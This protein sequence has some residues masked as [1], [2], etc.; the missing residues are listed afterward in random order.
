MK[1]INSPP[2]SP[3][4][5]CAQSCQSVLHRDNVRALLFCSV[6]DCHIYFMLSYVDCYVHVAESSGGTARRNATQRRKRPR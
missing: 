6:F 4:T 3:V 5:A 1:M 2:Q